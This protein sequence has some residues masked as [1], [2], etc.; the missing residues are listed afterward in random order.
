MVLKTWRDATREKRKQGIGPKRTKLQD[1]NTYRKHKNYAAL[2]TKTHPDDPYLFNP[3]VHDEASPR[4][5]DMMWRENLP[6]YRN[7]TAD[8]AGEIVF[9]RAVP[10]AADTERVTSFRLQHFAETHTKRTPMD[11][12][13][14][15]PHRVMHDITC[16]TWGRR[17]AGRL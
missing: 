10:R 1:L 8:G 4:K 13:S 12:F 16:C 5:I 3:F 9:Q 14:N 7:P 11:T 6:H 17:A 15:Y 2:N